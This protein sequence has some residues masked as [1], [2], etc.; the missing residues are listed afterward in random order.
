MLGL[1]V[2]EIIGSLAFGKIIDNCSTKVTVSICLVAVTVSYVFLFLYGIIYEFS[3]PLAIAM[4]L[5]WG[6]QDAGV[7]NLLNCMLGF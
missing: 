3:F 6:F 4:T 1:G 2:G 7:R 5:T